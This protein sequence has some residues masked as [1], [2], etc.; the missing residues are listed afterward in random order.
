MKEK[1]RLD[2]LLVARGMAP[3]REKAQAY[4]LAGNVL[5]NDQ[6]VDKPGSSV[7]LDAAIRLKGFDHPY[8]SRGGLKLEAALQEF[9]IDVHNR[10]AMDIGAS[11]GGFTDCLLQNGAAYVFSVDVG[12]G[13]LDWKLVTDE[14]VR[15]IEKTNFR[16]LSL[17][18][19]GSFV[20]V[21][22]IDV[23]FISLTKILQN[24]LQFLSVGGNLIALI[25]PQFEAGKE[26]IRK[27]G[28]VSDP[29]IRSTVIESV[30]EHAV[31]LSYEIRD[32]R[33][34]PIQGKKSGNV[35]YLLHL[36]KPYQT[37]SA[38]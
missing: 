16:Y 32:V 3:S 19:V 9:N 21:I 10:I 31:S 7:S 15:N 18:E 23:S 12:Y 1:S 5:V 11:T 4:I 29:G 8:V 37:Q 35:E 34:S 27:G 24:C 25:K 13:Q 38:I 26:N 17:T 20:D 36:V 22:V 33:S 6:K 14:R 28:I 30:K 2:K